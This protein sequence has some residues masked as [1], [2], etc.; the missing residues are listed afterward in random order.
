MT[1]SIPLQSSLLLNAITGLGFPLGFTDRLQRENLL[2]IWEKGKGKGKRK[3]SN[4]RDRKWKE[5]AGGGGEGKGQK[6]PR[7]GSVL[8][9]ASLSSEETVVTEVTL[10]G[11]MPCL[12]TIRRGRP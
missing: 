9:F 1:S 11:F 3:R 12:P 7:A 10:L 5:V 2:G 6:K 4:K 8:K